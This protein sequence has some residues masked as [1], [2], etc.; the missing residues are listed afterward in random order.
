M[1][2]TC[3]FE[4]VFD[5]EGAA[6]SAD[7][8]AFVPDVPNFPS[9]PKGGFGSLLRVFCF[10]DLALRVPLHF[11]LYVSEGLRTKGP[12]PRSLPPARPAP[13]LLQ[14]HAIRVKTSTTKS[15]PKDSLIQAQP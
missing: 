8:V 15:Q 10:Q 1:L 2:S 3:L 6:A 13:L 7:R 5:C 11:C 14:R 9:F 12:L 4:V